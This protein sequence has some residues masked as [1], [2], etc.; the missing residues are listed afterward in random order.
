LRFR[1][2]P[3]WLIGMFGLCSIIDFVIVGDYKWASISGLMWT[4][5]LFSGVFA[6]GHPV[7]LTWVV[8]DVWWYIAV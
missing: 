1:P 2:G 4:F 5:A 8:K 6:M 3:A 7:S